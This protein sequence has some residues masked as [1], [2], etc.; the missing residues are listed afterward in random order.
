MRFLAVILPLLLGPHPVFADTLRVAVASNF[1]AT[2]QALAERFE[3]TSD[4][5][6]K[7]AF[8]STGKHYGQIVHGAPFDAFLAADAERPRRLE[9]EGRAITGT[10]FTYAI[11]RLALWSPIPGLVD[12]AGQVLGSDRYTHL[13]I[14]NPRLAPYGMAAQQVLQ[15]LQLWESLQNRLIRGENIGQ[16]FRFV[17]G[18]GAQLGFV[19]L[20]QVRHPDEPASGSLWLPPAGYYTPIEQQAVL[21]NEKPAARAFLQFLAS[22][23]ARALIRAH[24]YETP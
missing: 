15:R 12:S 11:G 4:H 14:A 1:A 7:L 24:G 2:A 3:Q 13:A 16:T 10:R 5:R 8:G 20:S 9:A 17:K 6:I 18:G 21:L 22:A 23:P 19:A